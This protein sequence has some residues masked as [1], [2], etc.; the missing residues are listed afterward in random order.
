[1]SYPSQTFATFDE[2][3]AY[4]NSYWI[5]NGVQEITGLIGNNGV[6]G[7]LTFIRKSPL[8]WQKAQI[9]SSTG[10]VS[11][12][13][14]IV[15]FTG[16]PN[17]LS[18]AD[19]IYFEYVFINTTVGDIPL[20]NPTNYFDINL[21]AVTK[22]PAKSIVNL[23]KTNNNQWIV[24]SIPSS[25]GQPSLP[26]LIG[27]VDGGGD[28]DPVSGISIFQSNKLKGLGSSNNG[29]INIIIDGGTQQN[30]GNNQTMDFDPDL[31]EIDL[32]F[33]SSGNTWQTGQSLYIDLNQ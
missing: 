18:F 19:N 4:F 24:G 21:N 10:N 9:S 20:L 31:G 25:G 14:P 29:R 1:M 15:V 33:N 26:P 6:N 7:L 8:N 11:A 3:L 32:D 28:D 16:V 27:I 5:T 2:L 23:V 12:V 22:I 17:S 30:F 13:R